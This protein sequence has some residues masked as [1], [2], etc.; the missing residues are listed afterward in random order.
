MPQLVKRGKKSSSCNNIP[1]T[2]PD[3]DTPTLVEFYEG[4]WFGSER[5]VGVSTTERLR[6]RNL[7]T[8]Y[9]GKFSQ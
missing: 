3:D 4:K 8:K 1:I 2:L 5:L 9:L 6:A 7:T